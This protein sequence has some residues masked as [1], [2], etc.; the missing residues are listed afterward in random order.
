MSILDKIFPNF[1]LSSNISIWVKIFI[2]ISILVKIL[3]NLD[4]KVFWGGNLGF[5]Q[6]LTKFRFRSIFF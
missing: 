4:L 3:E 5:D 6:N 1:D 2:K